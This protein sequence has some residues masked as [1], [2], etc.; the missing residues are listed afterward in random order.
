M[1]SINSEKIQ[2]IDEPDRWQTN[3]SMEDI[4]GFRARLLRFMGEPHKVTEVSSIS[5]IIEITQE[6]VQSSLPVDLEI[7]FTKKPQINLKFD[8]FTQPMGARF[9]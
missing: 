4:V 7:K 2:I 9:C 3:M 6:Q 1:A 5:K 8:R